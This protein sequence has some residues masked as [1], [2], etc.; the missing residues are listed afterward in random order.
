VPSDEGWLYLAVVLDLFSRKIVGWAMADR[1]RTEL[2][3]GALAMA[4]AARG[5]RP[6]LVHH[7]D[8]GSQYTS[9]T[10]GQRCEEAGIRP[11]TG[12]TGACYDNAVTESFFASLESELIDR[13]TFPTRSDAEH[14]LFAYIE[15]FYNPRRRH[16]A[17]GQLSPVEFEHR[18]TADASANLAQS[19][20]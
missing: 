3:T 2:V 11:S 17:N 19:A 15:G 18:H 8:K 7:S 10:F 1:M 4:I 14:A 6:G 9:L 13:T 20:A 12:R 16:S 5:P